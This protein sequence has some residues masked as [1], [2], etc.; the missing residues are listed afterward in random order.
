MVAK[1]C[2]QQLA[3]ILLVTHEGIQSKLIGDQ[4]GLAGVNLKNDAV[5]AGANQPA[6]TVVV[7]A[8]GIEVILSKAKVDFM[9][10]T[11]HGA[12]AMNDGFKANLM[13]TRIIGTCQS[14][15]NR[16]RRI[17]QAG[18]YPRPT[19]ACLAH[20]IQTSCRYGTDVVE[21]APGIG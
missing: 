11:G 15:G 4:L 21:T 14:D 6:N 7:P 12:F 19:G 2:T 10:G 18:D 16:C 13:C 20:P 9:V 1:V 3:L 17:E 8:I 5:A